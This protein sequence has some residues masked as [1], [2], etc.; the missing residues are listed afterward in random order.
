M[1]SEQTT[2]LKRLYKER[3]VG[4]VLSCSLSRLSRAIFE[5][6]D[7]IW[8]L[9]ELGAEAEEI[10]PNLP[11]TVTYERFQETLDW[12]RMQNEPWMLRQEEMSVALSE[13]HYWLNSKYNETVM[14]YIKIGF[15]NVYINDYRKIIRFPDSVAF[16]YDTFIHPEYRGRRAA[17]YLVNESFKFL[18]SKG[19][20]K[21][22]CHIPSWNRTSIAVYSGLGFREVTT[23]R[24]VRFLGISFLNHNPAK[25]VL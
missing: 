20:T 15:R 25:L 4:G 18:S 8:F 24:C 10:K 12:I 6:N 16:I 11:I 7:A 14:G 5:T 17:S 23:V 21:I 1:L 22:L 2:K 13:G 9:K 19:F 3:G